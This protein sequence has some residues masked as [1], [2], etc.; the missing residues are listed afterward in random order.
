MM[1][2]KSFVTFAVDA[3]L[4]EVYNQAI[5]D[6]V[7]AV[8]IVYKQIIESAAAYGPYMALDKAI[9]AIEALRK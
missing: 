5:D 6:V 1:E 9:A 3:K 4:K 8:D 7:G 2:D